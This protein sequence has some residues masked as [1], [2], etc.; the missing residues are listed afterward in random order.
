MAQWFGSTLFN[1]AVTAAALRWGSDR[2]AHFNQCESLKLQRCV[3]L[4]FGTPP[5]DEGDNIVVV[6]KVAN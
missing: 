1:A 2:I 6:G 4:L 3:L 5:V